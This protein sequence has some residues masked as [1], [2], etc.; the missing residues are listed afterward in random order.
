MP[1]NYKHLVLKKEIIKNERRTR[2]MNIP[3]PNRGDIRIHGEKLNAYFG[4]AMQAAR[5]Q[6]E[7]SD[8][9]YVLKLRYDGPF[10]LANLKA[11]GVNFLSQEDK[12]LCVVFANEEGLAVFSDHIERLGLDDADITYKQILEA[13]EGI[14]SWTPEDRMSWAVQNKGFPNSDVFA[15]DI[16]L[17]PVKTVHHPER[18]QRRN[19][20]ENWLQTQ[21]IIISDQINLDSLV[22]YRVRVQLA[23]AKL[24]LTHS[25]VRLVDLIPNTGIKYQQL[26]L[27]IDKIPHPITRP[28][29]AASKIC[30][31]DSGINTNHPLLKP[32]IAESV[33]FLE[34]E[35]EFDQAGHG[36]AVASVALYG[37]LEACEASNYWEPK[38]WLYNGKILD[39]HASFDLLTIEH[40]I[41]N[42]VEY[43]VDLG[44]R[45]FNLSIG[46]ANAPYDGKHIRGISYVL[47]NLTREHNIL[48]IVSAGNFNGSEKP[49][50][51]RKSWRDE[52]PEYLLSDESVI[53]DPAP[54]LNVITVGSLAKNNASL[55]A[56]KYS[57]ISQ[58]SPASENQPSPF[59]RHGPSVKGA[60]KPDLVAVGGNLA[61][62]MRQEDAQWK[63]DNRGLGVLVC[64]NNFIGNTIFKEISGTSFAAPY[65]THLAGRLLNEYPEASANL[66][67]AMLVNHANMLDECEDI[68]T[69]ETIR[70]YKK[71]NANRELPREVVGYGKINEDILYRS[72]EDAVVLIAEELIENNSHEFFEL[73]LPEEFLRSK[74][75]LRELRVTLTYSPPV[76]TTRQDYR[77]SKLSFNL[78]KDTSLDSVQKCFNKSTQNETKKM[79]DACTQN[80]VVS[81]EIRSKGTVQSSTWN[82]KQLSPQYKWFIV[83]TRQ[84]LEWGKEM[85]NEKELYALVV[86]V[87]DRDN[88]TA[89]LYTEI[90]QRIQERERI[91]SQM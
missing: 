5:K 88:E 72:S 91:R 63:I 85:C 74:R 6:I 1:D 86:T 44:C 73:P 11:H 10:N 18:K 81:S 8:G 32:A 67:R 55:D 60:L 61:N 82:L 79:S 42:A 58:L 68:F 87:T 37:D 19:G 50:V 49:P 39:S 33:S 24:L 21:K 4:R 34:G 17:W 45:I 28:N 16:E 20:F 23:Q 77:A 46:N 66:L 47:D 71:S 89:R 90:R 52:Y 51:P 53:I 62:P 40:V 57:E 41:T 75:G 56:Q 54:A 22:M 30:I 27:D 80:R 7:S 25:D 29:D 38:I 84:D 59:T 69:K 83:V 76:R 3:R 13:L 36:T 64:N 14:D 15:L 35:D 9:S 78:V 65:I 26:N 31:L 43:F 70:A 12:Q 48:F 2:K